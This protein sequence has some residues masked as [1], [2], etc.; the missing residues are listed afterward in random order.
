MPIPFQAATVY[1]KYKKLSQ[2]L[3]PGPAM[4]IVF[5]DERCDSI[6]DG[7]WCTSMNGWDPPNRAAWVIIDGPGSY[8]G[9]ACGFAF[10][11]GHSEIHKWRNANTLAPIGRGGGGCISGAPDDAYWIMQ[12]STRK[13]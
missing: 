5:V 2:V 11:D 7:E 3:N 12:R 13:P 9:G 1:I 8:H 4:T 10:A 6:N